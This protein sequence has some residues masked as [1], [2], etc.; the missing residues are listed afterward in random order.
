VI[1]EFNDT[2]ERVTAVIT[3]HLESGENYDGA[4]VIGFYPKNN[5]EVFIQAQG[6]TINVALEDVDDLCRQLKRAK[7][8]A[9]GQEVEGG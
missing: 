2:T 1:T 6:I 8:I 5:A 7:K 3:S 4:I 9:A